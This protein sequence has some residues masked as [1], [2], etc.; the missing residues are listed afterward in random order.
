MK[1]TFFLLVIMF[2]MSIQT[3]GQTIPNSGF[4][5]WDIVGGWFEYPNSWITNNTQIT[6]PVL[7][8][9]NSFEGSYSLIISHKYSFH[10]GFATS[11]F[12]FL[13]HPTNILAYVKSEID[14]NDSVRIDISVFLEGKIVDSGQWVNTTSIST[15]TLQ[16]IPISQNSLV[17]DSLEIQIYGG[18]QKGTTINVDK[19]EYELTTSIDPITLDANWCLFPNPMTDF[20]KLTFNNSKR[21]KF[22][23]KLY[24]M[25]G[26]VVKTNDNITAEEVI[27]E[28]DNLTK[29][30]YL[31]MLRTDIKQAAFGK[32]VIE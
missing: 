24:N 9:T 26:Q 2:V 10:D 28:K 6:T 3:I 20:S 15:W 14:G 11:K 4:E 22:N 13:I 32:L 8:D 19:L 18:T 27:I 31:F 25:K 17:I 1:T 30:I 21:E 16:S 23:L 12:P 7:K 29:G 5:N